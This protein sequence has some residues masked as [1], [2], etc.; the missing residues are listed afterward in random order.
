MRETLTR[1]LYLEGQ[2]GWSQAAGGYGQL[3]AGLKPWENFA[4]YGLAR[5][6]RHGP[7]AAVGA[8]FEVKF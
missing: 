3:E 4:L 7:S 8:R 6:D 2:A 5:T 1:G